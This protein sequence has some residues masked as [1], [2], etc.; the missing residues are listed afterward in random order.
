MIQCPET[1]L[2]CRN[3]MKSYASTV[4]G[5]H[6]PKINC[7]DRSGCSAPILESELRR[8]LPDELMKLWERVSQR[9]EIEAAGLE[10]LEECPVCDYAVIIENA[11]DKLLRCGNVEVCGMVSCRA[12]KKPVSSS[13]TPHFQHLKWLLLYRITSRNGAMVCQ[14]T[15]RF[16]LTFY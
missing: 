9:K 5:V 1:H 11:E 14:T 6:D 16:L 2:V 4:L 13:Y 3:C 12:C 10:N 15:A 8:F 7:I